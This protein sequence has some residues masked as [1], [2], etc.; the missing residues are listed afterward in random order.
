MVERQSGDECGNE[1]QCV[2]GKLLDVHVHAQCTRLA[3]ER[4]HLKK[5]SK[6]CGQQER[7][8]FRKLHERQR[9]V[10]SCTRQ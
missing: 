4:M 5:I 8:V 2:A 6:I 9:D 10:N 3:I 1:C 7:L